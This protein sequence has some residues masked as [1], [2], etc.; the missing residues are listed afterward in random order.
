ML[1][2]Q[3]QTSYDKVITVLVNTHL[4]FPFTKSYFFRTNAQLE[5]NFELAK[6]STGQD[7]NNQNLKIERKKQLERYIVLGEQLTSFLPS[8]SKDEES[9]AQVQLE[10]DEALHQEL[11]CNSSVLGSWSAK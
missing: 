7:Y 10:D 9:K 11:I 2:G 6:S 4:V 3:I 1:V 8:T 5:P